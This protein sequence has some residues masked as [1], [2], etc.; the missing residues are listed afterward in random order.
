MTKDE[1]VALYK[2]RLLMGEINPEVINLANAKIIIQ[3]GKQ[4]TDEKY[5]VTLEGCKF[6]DEELD[7]EGIDEIGEW[8]FQENKYIKRV[9]LR[10]TKV[11]ALGA[12]RGCG[13][14][15]S[16]IGEDVEIVSRFSFS[17]CYNLTT[18]RFP[19]VKKV[20]GCAFQWCTELN[21]IDFPDVEVIQKSAFYNCFNLSKCYIRK[22]K[23]IG[24]EVFSHCHSLREIDIQSAEELGNNVFSSCQALRSVD[25]PMLSNCGSGVFGYCSNLTVCC[26]GNV[27]KI[28]SGTFCG[29]HNLTSLY[30]KYCK[31][32]LDT[33][34]MFSCQKLRNLHLHI[35]A[36][37]GLLD[38]LIND[39]IAFSHSEIEVYFYYNNKTSLPSIMQPEALLEYSLA[40]LT[41]ES[42]NRI[43]YID[44][45]SEVSV[46]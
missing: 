37:C 41:L 46:S 42:V 28:K 39:Q 32:F 23:K 2:N 45:D 16:V 26:L 1:I 11:V 15:V 9:V 43:K 12:F 18:V 24:D 8:V 17:G 27:S 33:E 35:F 3:E 19:T 10:G 21:Y 22:A 13:N 40:H 14:L 5:W 44:E 38:V 34:S 30:A 31:D 20:G 4:D 25:A 6:Y 7:I 29:C 36:A